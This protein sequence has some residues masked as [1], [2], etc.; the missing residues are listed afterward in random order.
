MERHILEGEK[1]RPSRFLTTAVIATLAATAVPTSAAHAATA[2]LIPRDV[3]TLGGAWS[4]PTAL[5]NSGYLVGSSETATGA[6]HAFRWRNGT[7]S[8]LGTL[9]GGGS[10]YAVDVNERG[11]VAGTAFTAAGAARPFLWRRGVLRDLA[12]VTGDGISV[13]GL[14]DLGRVIG[15]RYTA[16]S[17]QYGQAFVWRDGVATDLPGLGGD[18]LADDINNRGDIAGSTISADGAETEAALWRDGRLIRLTPPVGIAS[19]AIDVNERGQVVG[20]VRVPDSGW[21]AFLWENGV[22]T[23]LGALGGTESYP[24]GIND[25][26]QVGGNAGDS[27][28]LRAVRWHRGTATDLAAL[29]GVPGLATAMNGAGSVAGVANLG[30]SRGVVWRGAGVVDLGPLDRGVTGGSVQFINDRGLVAGTIAVTGA[31][32]H[33]VVWNIGRG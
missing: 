23:D 15:T 27:S 1:M 5:S 8:D 20:T 28:D 24:V 10:S 9:P 30:G 21:H 17:G 7:L 6:T 32:S 16:T 13:T 3:G 11:D 31:G 25:R 22:F 26:G 19:I 33:A 4:N 12:A 18:T 29:S 14:N 2:P